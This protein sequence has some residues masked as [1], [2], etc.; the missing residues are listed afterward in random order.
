MPREIVQ[1]EYLDDENGLVWI[2][3]KGTTEAE[4]EEGC[5][6]ARVEREASGVVDCPRR[7]RRRVRRE[8]LS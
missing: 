4:A 8:L 5:S 1:I 6:R 7:L 2:S 3:G